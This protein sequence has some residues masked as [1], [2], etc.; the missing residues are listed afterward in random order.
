MSARSAKQPH[1][2]RR[3]GMSSPT[4]STD[5]ANTGLN[6][7]LALSY[8]GRWDIA[9]AARSS[10]MPSAEGTRSCGDHRGNGGAHLPRAARPIPTCSFGPAVNGGSVIFS[11]GKQPIRNSI[12][13][14]SGRNSEV[15]LYNAIEDYQHRERRFGMVSAQVQSEPP[16]PSSER[17]ELKN[18]LSF[19]APSSHSSSS[20]SSAPPDLFVRHPAWRR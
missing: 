6:L 7:C 5:R 20:C 17:I 18:V 8:S 9:G 16:S 15:E 11:S 2:Q 13:A 4:P 14:T 19:T 1:F 12:S 10:P 3:S